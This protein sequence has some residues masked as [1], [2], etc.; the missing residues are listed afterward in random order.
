MD[1]AI[2]QVKA[3][4]KGV[5]EAA[6][7]SLAQMAKST[8]YSRSCIAN[9]ES[10]RRAR[11]GGT[12]AEYVAAYDKALSTGGLL[13]DFWAALQEGD[14]VKRRAVVFA[15]STVATVGVS[16]RAY[17]AEALRGS[18]LGALGGEDW[19]EL[20]AEYGRRFMTSPP[21]VFHTH[22]AGDL[23]NLKSALE[24]SD[25]G[26]A[27]AAA[28]R[29]MTLQ[30]MGT[31][32]LGDT[33]AA[34]R[35]YRAARVA[36]DMTDDAALRAWVRAREAFR[37]GYEGSEPAE[38]L[39]VAAGV[40]GQVEAH[41]ALAQ[42]YARMGE[43]SPALTALDRAR[44]AHEA[45]DHD[46]AT[47]FAMPGW[48]MALSTAYVYALLGMPEKCEMELSASPPP[49]LRRWGA[50]YRMQTAVALSRSGDSV[51]GTQVAQEVMRELPREQ[52]SIVI[53]QMYR[54]AT[55]HDLL[56]QS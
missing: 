22:L 34:L 47:I 53:E 28:A 54:E 48:R 44:R 55:R 33:G 5:R 30:A 51:T 9:I 2:G 4:M 42:A 19:P 46:E 49:T 36:A 17:V 43:T 7:L 40:E 50:Q 16:S 6:G 10:P 41:L 23:I 32:N 24:R 56:T 3:K 37:R 29:M 14:E 45:A 52:R 26:A 27:R 25:S 20:A 13:L 18:I 35:W 12:I 15:L 31:A 39:A 8:G 21:A 11:G 38:V 1:E